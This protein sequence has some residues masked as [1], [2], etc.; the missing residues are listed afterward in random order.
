MTRRH[1]CSIRSRNC[2]D[3]RSAPGREA[4]MS[5]SKVDSSASGLSVQFISPSANKSVSAASESA[6]T[7]QR[8]ANYAVASASASNSAADAT[9]RKDKDTS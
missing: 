9:A 5:S 3:E 4:K 7:S 2:G 1:V 6:K 8:I